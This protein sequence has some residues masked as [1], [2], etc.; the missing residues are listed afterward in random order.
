MSGR[1]IQ[2]IW[3]TQ[4]R[5]TLELPRSVS[6]VMNQVKFKTVDYPESD[7]QPMGETDVHRDAMFRII[8]LLKRHFRH[9]KVYVSGDL[10]LYY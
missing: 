5:V 9:Q 7:G 10:L 6:D 4:P 2:S 8:E 3:A 1:Q